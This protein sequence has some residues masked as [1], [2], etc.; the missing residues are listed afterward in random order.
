VFQFT[1]PPK[2]Q[3]ADVFGSKE[4]FHG[5]GR[6]MILVEPQDL[7]KFFSVH[8]TSAD[9]EMRETNLNA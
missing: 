7:A 9:N 3:C 6:Q 1:V 2:N 5:T 8:A 4:T